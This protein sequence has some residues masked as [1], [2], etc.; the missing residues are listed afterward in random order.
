VATD[1]KQQLQT[2]AADLART[3]HSV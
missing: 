1:D 3:H 2:N